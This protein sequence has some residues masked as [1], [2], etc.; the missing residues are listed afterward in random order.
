MDEVEA[1]L[2]SLVIS[3]EKQ[4]F[5][6]NELIEIENVYAINYSIYESG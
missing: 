3:D 5:S 1:C 4:G 2:V 6:E